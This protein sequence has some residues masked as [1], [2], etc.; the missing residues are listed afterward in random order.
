MAGLEKALG[1]T[2]FG[3]TAEGLVEKLP[4]KPALVPE[5]DKRPPY[6]AAAIAFGGGSGG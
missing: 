2:V 3:K 6:N 4:G 5:S 1:K